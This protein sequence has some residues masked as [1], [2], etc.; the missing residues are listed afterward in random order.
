LALDSL[1]DYVFKRLSKNRFTAFKH[2]LKIM[3]ENSLTDFYHVRV[4]LSTTVYNRF[5][6]KF[7]E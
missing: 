1:S 7:F 3:E 4:S 2:V 6:R 5:A